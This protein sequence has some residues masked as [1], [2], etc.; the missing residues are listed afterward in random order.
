MELLPK[1]WQ[2]TVTT[3]WNIQEGLLYVAATIYFWKISRHWFYFVMV[4]EI[5]VIISVILLF[6]V[7]ESPRWLI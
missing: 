6:W 7:P 1:K 3:I 2:T 5:W 4:G